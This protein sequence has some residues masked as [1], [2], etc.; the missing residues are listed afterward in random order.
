MQQCDNRQCAFGH[1]AIKEG[2]IDNCFSC[3]IAIDASILVPIIHTYEALRIT[4]EGHA[5]MGEMAIKFPNTASC[6]VEIWHQTLRFSSAQE[7]LQNKYI[8]DVVCNE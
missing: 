1:Q 7:G 8:A 5:N 6:A 4:V 2:Q 3:K